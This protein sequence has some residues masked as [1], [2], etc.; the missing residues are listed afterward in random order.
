MSDKNFQLL[1]GIAAQ[2]GVKVQELIRAVIIPDWSARNS[3]KS[4]IL[5]LLEN[6]AARSSL[7]YAVKR[8]EDA[9]HV[10][11]RLFHAVEASRSLPRPALVSRQKETDVSRVV[12][13]GAR[14]NY[15]S[16]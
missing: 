5:S 4:G 16:Q 11:Q 12:Q 8:S 6:S 15:R 3:Q 9:V 14:R 2:R 7:T 10:N 1:A 13:S